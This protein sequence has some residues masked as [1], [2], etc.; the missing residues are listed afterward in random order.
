MLYDAVLF[1][2]I[3]IVYEFEGTTL[4]FLLRRLDTCLH[5]RTARFAHF[6][7][8]IVIVV[9]SSSLWIRC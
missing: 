8:I 4:E 9:S 6:L 1:G 3:P 2:V 7:I 5:G